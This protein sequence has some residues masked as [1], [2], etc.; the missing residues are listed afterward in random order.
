MQAYVKAV[1]AGKKWQ[2]TQLTTDALLIL[3]Q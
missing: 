2:E 3:G 1:I